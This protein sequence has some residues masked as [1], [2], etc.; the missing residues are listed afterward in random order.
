MPWQSLALR[1][2]GP[3]IGSEGQQGKSGALPKGKTSR[4]FQVLQANVTKLSPK[5]IKWLL[6]QQQY[7]IL[8][9][10]ELQM[11]GHSMH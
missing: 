4:S 10:Q 3:N 1:D 9:L 7:S 11:L 5:I 8:L 6:E 2:V